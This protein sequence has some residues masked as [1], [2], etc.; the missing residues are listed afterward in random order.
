MANQL[1]YRMIN[2]FNFDVNI[3]AWYKDFL[4]GRKTRVK[5]KKCTTKWRNSLENLPQGQTDSTILFDL[6]INYINLN[7]VDKI[8]SDMAKLDAIITND[9]QN[10]D[11]HENDLDIHS[12][13]DEEKAD[14]LGDVNVTSG[15]EMNKRNNNYNNY[16][17]NSKYDGKMIDIDGMKYMELHMNI[18]KKLHDKFDW[19]SVEIDKN[20]INDD[21]E[22]ININTTVHLSYKL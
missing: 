7:N 5:Y 15:G 21:N 20:R 17:C 10:Q 19:N 4:K 14:V 12:D 16:K 1:L 22:T 3:I 9:Y 13:S 11:N 18:R 6:M 2:E 8:A